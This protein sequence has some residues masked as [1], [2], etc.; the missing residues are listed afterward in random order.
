MPK[1]EE[2]KQMGQIEIDKVDRASLVDIQTVE[3]D[4]SL[5]VDKRMEEYLAQIKN[6]YCFLCD[7]SIVKMRFDENGGKLSE[8]IKNYF[9]NTKRD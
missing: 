5:S 8:K 7:N 4:S 2:L 9:I 1:L 6:P 3:I